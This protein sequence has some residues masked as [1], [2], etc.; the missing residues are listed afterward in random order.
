MSK[1]SRGEFAYQA[2]YRYLLTLTRHNT[3]CNEPKLPSLRDLAKRLKVSLSTVQHAYN[4]LEHEGYVRSVPKSGYYINRSIDGAQRARPPAPAISAGHHSLHLLEPPLPAM[5]ALDHALLTEERR[6]ARQG[7]RSVHERRLAGEL[8]LRSAL[9][10]RY[11]QS[12]V[13]C[14]SAE[15][16]YLATDLQT[17]LE[18]VFA[19]LHLENEAILV[20]SPVC[21]RLL[22]LLNQTGRRVVELPLD[23]RGCPDLCALAHLLRHERIGLAMLPSC[24]ASPLGRVMSMTAQRAMAALLDQHRVWVLEND[25]DSEHC[26]DGPPVARLRDALD[27]ERLLVLGSLQACVGAEAPYLYVLSDHEPVRQAFIWRDFRLPPLRQ[28]ALARLLVKGQVDAHLQVVR[29]ELASRMDAL[30]A[31]IARQVPGQLAFERPSGGR[32]L[33]GRVYQETDVQRVLREFS[34]KGLHAAPGPMFSARGWHRQYILLAWEGGRLN[35][36]RQAVGLLRQRLARHRQP[37]R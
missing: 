27:P 15:D 20:P 34:V 14:W 8:M 21:A 35:D 37:D 5:P 4:Q 28:H 19:A 23:A 2:V 36:L 1:S 30:C 12:S 10:T 7:S 31:E 17:L 16:V 29:R 13:H 24:L 3:V 6:L 22:W 9:A 33:W 25:L 32:G 11:T 18:T 26:F